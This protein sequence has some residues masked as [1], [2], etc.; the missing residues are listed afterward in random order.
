MRDRFVAISITV[1]I[2]DFWGV[3]A[4]SFHGGRESIQARFYV[5]AN[6]SRRKIR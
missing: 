5:K 3:E 1:P 6:A 4:M 2:G